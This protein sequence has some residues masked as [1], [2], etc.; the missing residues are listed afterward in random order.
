M[1]NIERVYYWLN[2]NK[3]LVPIIK[4]DRKC[5]KEIEK[6]D[7]HILETDCKEFENQIKIKINVYKLN[8]C[9]GFN[10]KN[11]IDYCMNGEI[12]YV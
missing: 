1:K 12:Y 10:F 9:E 7:F 5:G 11:L 8:F 3:K 2:G 4:G 6:A